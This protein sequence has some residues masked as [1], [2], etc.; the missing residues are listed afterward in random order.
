M[1]KTDQRIAAIILT[2]CIVLMVAM[3][4][5]CSSEYWNSD[6][7]KPWSIVKQVNES[8]KGTNYG[9]VTEFGGSVVAGFKSKEEAQAA[10]K[11][12]KR[13]IREDKKA[14]PEKKSKMWEV[15]K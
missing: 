14:K 6:K 15:V 4:A 1:N 9:Y 12:S 10:V 2:I 8:F 5:D 13:H 11:E 3:F 7:L